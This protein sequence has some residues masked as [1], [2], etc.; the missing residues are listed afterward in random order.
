MTSAQP[1]TSAGRWPIWVVS[2]PSAQDRRAL[3][4]RNFAAAGLEFEFFDA[5]DGRKGLAPEYEAM[6]DRVRTLE[7]DGTPMT[8]GEYACALSHQAVYLRIIEEDLPGAIVLE[9]DAMLTPAFRQFYLERGY[10][11]APLIQMFYFQARVWKGRGKTMTSG[12]R[13]YRLAEPAFAATGYSISH[14]AA[15]RI[16]AESLP[17]R[18]PAD[19]PCDT[20]R[21][22]AHV[23]VPRLIMHPDPAEQA[24][25]LTESRAQKDVSNYDPNRR[26]PKGWRRLVSPASWRRFAMKK[27]SRILS[28]GFAPGPDEQPYRL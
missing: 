4:A 6:V 18:A 1:S 2:L 28:P 20:A 13:L 11:A 26:F 12:I 7:R 22:G 24:S 17:I 27:A 10:E 19:W 16:R 9:D 3:I 23:T 25:T 15:R 8:D 5:I 14:E 21:L